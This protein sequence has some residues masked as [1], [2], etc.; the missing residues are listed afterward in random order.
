M[1][2][3]LWDWTKMVQSM[4]LIQATHSWHRKYNPNDE[5]GNEDDW[6]KLNSPCSF[7]AKG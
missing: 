1:S 4:K 7:S 5:N 3:T 6:K 2:T